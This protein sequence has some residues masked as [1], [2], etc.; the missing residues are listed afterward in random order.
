MN[1]VCAWLFCLDEYMILVR[2]MKLKSF[3]LFELNVWVGNENFSL[4]E[5]DDYFNLNMVY[6]F[7]VVI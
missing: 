7:D 4:C 5:L 2:F 3:V 1:N 6:K